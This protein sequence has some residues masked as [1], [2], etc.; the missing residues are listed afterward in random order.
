[1]APDASGE[2]LE[3]V[4]LGLHAGAWR[5]DDLRTPP[6]ADER[7]A[8]V[9]LAA[10]LSSDAAAGAAVER[11][12]AI[13]EGQSLARRLAMMPGNL[14][15]PAFL[16]DTARDIAQ[17]HGLTVDVLGRDGLEAEK[18]GSFLCVAQ[19]TPQEPQLITLEYRRGE[20]KPVVLV[21]KGLCF[22]TG[23][24]SI[25]PAQSMEMMKFDMCGAAGVLGAME[26]I[27]RLDLKINVVGIIGATTNMPSGTA[28]KPGDVVRSRSG[29]TI[30]VI[31]TDAEGRLVLADLLDYAARFDP[32]AVV[33]AAT[34]TGA[35]V[36][37]LGHVA[38][39]LFANDQQL[40]DELREAAEDAWDRVWQLPLWEEYQEQLRSNF[41]DFAN[42]GG[43]PGGSITAASF[44]ARFTRKQRW[45]HL[46]IAGT[47]WKSGREK[48]STGRPVPLLV[49]FALR[50]AGRK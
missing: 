19:G 6:P 20:G 35:C 34:L 3:H 45:A 8:P 18:M 49:R 23:G 11:G 38:T 32:A 40:A 4:A 9:E 36:I 27:A 12:N 29:K 5:Y 44:L 10:V 42:I 15:T 28:V 41:A 17:R 22:D 21:G 1:L 14:C 7:R 33:D 30:E 50:H 46:D 43:R 39:G 48:G 13:G 24:I 2:E 47:A 37:A 16:A 31:N 26:A 25:K